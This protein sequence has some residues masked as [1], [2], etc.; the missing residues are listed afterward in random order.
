MN[1]DT[2][3]RRPSGTWPAL[4]LPVA[5]LS[6]VALAWE[7]GV[8]TAGVPVY[9]LPAPSKIVLSLVAH[10][11]DLAAAGAVTLAEALLGFALG[12]CVSLVAAALMIHSQTLERSLLPLAILLKVTPVVAVAPLLVIWL[13]FGLAPKAVVAALI[14]F[15]PMLIN[16]LA[17]FRAV[18]PEAS[19]LLTTLAASRWEV[20]RLLRWPSALPYLFAGAR[21]A[22][23]LSLIGAVV[24]EW[25]GAERGLGRAVLLAYTNLDL[26]WLFAAVVVLAALGIG[27]TAA[28]AVLERRIV[29]W[30]DAGQE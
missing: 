13:G 21:V 26:P 10:A 1:A 15:Y 17:G 27:L 18:A 7:A 5:V 3:H 29:F 14:T 24:G 22:I 20:F 28:L 11:P 16:A 4:L 30:T 8:V 9:V 25:A 2:S 6:V 23:P 19:D 12:C